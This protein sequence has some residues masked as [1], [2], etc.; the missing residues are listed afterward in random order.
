MANFINSCYFVVELAVIYTYNIVFLCRE[1]TS[2][3]G[4]LSCRKYSQDCGVYRFSWGCLFIKIS[5]NMLYV[6]IIDGPPNWRRK[7]VDLK[8]YSSCYSLLIF[9][10]W[11]KFTSWKVLTGMLNILKHQW[12]WFFSLQIRKTCENIN[13]EK[14]YFLQ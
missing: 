5:D 6:L 12:F 1:R 14:N 4:R 7:W 3:M 8:Y 10:F 13:H 9:G 2:L 11:I